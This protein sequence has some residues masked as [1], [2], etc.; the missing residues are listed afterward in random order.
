MMIRVPI[1]LIAIATALAAAQ[2]GKEFQTADGLVRITLVA[3]GS[4]SSAVQ[5][6]LAASD[7]ASLDASNLIPAIGCADAVLDIYLLEKTTGGELRFP[8]RCPQMRDVLREHPVDA[9]SEDERVVGLVRELSVDLNVHM[10]DA[11]PEEEK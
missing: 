10:K 2:S 3:K 8:I 5:D 6:T 1:F 11:E 7:S 4:D 9:R